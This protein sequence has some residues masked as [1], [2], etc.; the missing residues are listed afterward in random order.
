[1]AKAREITKQEIRLDTLGVSKTAPLPIQVTLAQAVIKGKPMELILQKATE[2]GASRIVPL[3]SERSVVKLDAADR[4]KK[5]AKWERV[6]IEA[7]KQ[8]GQNWLP[9]LEDAQSVESFLA[10]PPNA[11]LALLA[12]LHA[13]ARQ[14]PARDPP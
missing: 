5:A 10:Q 13:D 6:L 9:Q 2:L 1:M 8:S 4:E 3:L 12:S 7:C 11:D 14:L